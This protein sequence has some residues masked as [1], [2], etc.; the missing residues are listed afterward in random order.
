MLL[1]IQFAFSWRKTNKLSLYQ[2]MFEVFARTREGHCRRRTCLHVL[3]SNVQKEVKGTINLASLK[4]FFKY[5][6]QKTVHIC[7]V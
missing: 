3:S 5:A 2:G 1:L 4:C 7:M 6:T